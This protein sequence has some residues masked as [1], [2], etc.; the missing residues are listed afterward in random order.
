M[1]ILAHLTFIIFLVSTSTST[2]ADAGWTNYVYVAD[3]N[4]TI[5]ERYLF[6]L[7]EVK[8]PSGCKNTDWFYQDFDATG[9]NKIFDVLLHALVYGKTVRVYV[10]GKCELKGYSE[11][12][13]VS[14]V[15]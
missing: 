8:N 7:K 15:P 2:Y 13:S 14:I 10:T 1:K 6:R 12:S 3:L 9:S 11:I 5:H 4:P